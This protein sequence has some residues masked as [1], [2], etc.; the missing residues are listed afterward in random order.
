MLLAQRQVSSNVYRIY[1]PLREVV[2]PSQGRLQTLRRTVS[3]KLWECNASARRFREH[4][5]LVDRLVP[6][7]MPGPANVLGTTRSTSLRT[8]K[9][10]RAKFG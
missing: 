3:P 2:P 10:L 9:A 1:G 7:A 5:G 8:P 4:M 6:K